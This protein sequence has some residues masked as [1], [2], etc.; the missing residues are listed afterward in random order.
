MFPPRG[1]TPTAFYSSELSFTIAGL[2][3]NFQK[4]EYVYEA[5]D[6]VAVSL[7][8][9]RHILPS[10]NIQSSKVHNQGALIAAVG[11]MP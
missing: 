1:E 5:K 8:V 3:T 7:A 4:H 2:S 10:G 11:P 9:E 6:E